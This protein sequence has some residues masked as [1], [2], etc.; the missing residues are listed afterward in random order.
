MS[1]SIYV[2][3]LN[4]NGFSDTLECVTSLMKAIPPETLKYQVVVVDNHSTDNSYPMLQESL[5]ASVIL[6]DSKRNGG[7]AFGNNVGIRFALEHSADYV[8]ILNNDTIITEDFLS[9]CV[10]ELKNNHSIAFISPMLMNYYDDLVQNT[11]GTI[12]I[13]RGKSTEM[14]KNVSKDSIQKGL[15]SCDIVYGAAMV[16]ESRLIQAIGFLPENYFLFYEETEWCYKAKQAGMLNCIN[17]KTKIIHKK[18]ESLKAMSEMQKYLMERNRTLFVK[19]NG[20]PFEFVVFLLYDFGRTLYRAL[21][22]NISIMQYLKFHYDGIVERYD[23][24]YVKN[25]ENC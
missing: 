5:P 24:C 12:S 4:Y 16:F 19:R 2:I 7:Y 20:S 10:A 15:I 13:L 1:N 14:N 25:L 11:G 21:F 3:V 17:S 18:S 9:P 6:L 22:H 23:P 8:C